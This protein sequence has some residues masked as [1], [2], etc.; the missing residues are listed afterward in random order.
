MMRLKRGGVRDDAETM[1]QAR[2]GRRECRTSRGAS[3]KAKPWIWGGGLARC[4]LQESFCDAIVQM[5]WGFGPGF[6]AAV[7]LPVLLDAVGLTPT[8]AVTFPGLL[9]GDWPNIIV[10]GWGNG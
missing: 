10:G 8:A 1:Q 7:V 3:D 6:A 9:Q 2:H 4:A 5:T